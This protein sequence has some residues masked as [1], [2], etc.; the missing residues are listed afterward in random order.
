MGY[1]I[2]MDRHFHNPLGN[3]F[4]ASLIMLLAGW[5]G[6]GWLILFTLPGVWQRWGFFFLLTLALTGTALPVTNYLNLRFPTSPPAEET[7]ILRQAILLG[8]YGS[9]L[10]WLQ[11][12]G[13]VTAWTI[14]GFGAGLVTIEYLIR[15]RE[16]SRWQPPKIDEGSPLIPDG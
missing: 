12:G 1:N 10:A 2:F 6:L 7:S 14:I 8:I 16:K 5:G 4:P 9:T 11:L 3:F 13:I 15:L